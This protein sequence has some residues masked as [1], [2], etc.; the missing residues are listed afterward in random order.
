MAT[1]HQAQY[2]A[3]CK[4]VV[5]AIASDQSTII[6]GKAVVL[7][8]DKATCGAIFL[9]NQSMVVSQTKL[10]KSI[11]NVPLILKKPFQTH[12]LKSVADESPVLNTTMNFSGEKIV[13]PL[14]F[15]LQMVEE[16][17]LTS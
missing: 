17:I 14:L 16:L 13:N 11:S 4:T 15:F 2:T 5:S 7:A 8:G 10:S 9:G 6:N 1:K 12:K 3:Q